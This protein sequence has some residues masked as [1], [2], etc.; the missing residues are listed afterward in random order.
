MQKRKCSDCGGELVLAVRGSQAQTANDGPSLIG[1]S[2][3][4]WRCST[5]GSAF[6][7]TQLRE[8]KRGRVKVAEPV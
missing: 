7:A 1:S 2:F 3:T 4:N 6:T 8:D 5:C